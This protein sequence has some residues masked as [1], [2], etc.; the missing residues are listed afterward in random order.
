MLSEIGVKGILTHIR[1]PCEVVADLR[2][3]FD[4]HLIPILLEL[5]Q[6]ERPEIPEARHVETGVRPIPP[7][8]HQSPSHFGGN[9]S[10]LPLLR[11]LL[12]FPNTPAPQ[13]VAEAARGTTLVL[14]EK[15]LLA[16][17]RP[18]VDGDPQLAQGQPSPIQTARR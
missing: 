1:W 8:L 15:E 3:L 9:F 5:L 2:E 4:I 13:V 11:D 10:P 7:T 14:Q 6:R 17:Q 12:D 18:S 16:R